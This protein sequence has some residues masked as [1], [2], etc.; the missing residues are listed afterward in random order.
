MQTKR[1]SKRVTAFFL[2]FLLISSFATGLFH[3]AFVHGTV[4]F[5]SDIETGDLSDFTSTFT[6]G[7]TI[8]A[9]SA[10]AHGGTYSALLSGLGSEGECAVAYKSLGA[11]TDT[12]ARA[13][14]R[15]PSLPSSSIATGLEFAWGTEQYYDIVSVGF[16]FS[17]NKWYISERVNAEYSWTTH[18]ESGTS[19]FSADTWYCIELRHYYHASAG[20]LALWVD[21][22][23]KIELTGIVTNGFQT[24]TLWIGNGYSGGY[25]PDQSM[26]IDDIV[27][28]NEYIGPIAETEY[29]PYIQQASDIDSAA[30]VGT[31]SNFTAQ[32]YGPDLI[33]D[34]LT[35]AT[36]LYNVTQI[37]EGFEGDWPPTGWTEDPSNSRWNKDASQKYSGS[38][39]A[40]Y[41][42]ATANVGDLL[43]P[44]L[45][46]TG[47]AAVYISF[48][49]FDDDC[50][51]NE[52]TYDYYDNTGNWDN[53]GDLA[54]STE[55]TF[56]NRINVK[57]TDSQYLHSAFKLRIDGATIG[58]G[59]NFYVDDFL[60][61]A[62]YN[63]YT[64]SLE[65]QFTEIPTGYNTRQLCIY[66]GSFNGAENLMVQGWNTG[67]SSW[68]TISSA[69]TANQWNNLTI[70]SWINELNTTFYIRFIDALQSADAAQ[71]TWQID[72]VYLWMYNSTEQAYSFSLY[73]T[74]A[75]ESTLASQKGVHS[76][77]AVTVGVE[78]ASPFRRLLSRYLNEVVLVSEGTNI[79]KA[80]YR[81][82]DE[83]VAL[84]DG[85]FYSRGALRI[86]LENL[87]ASHLDPAILKALF[88]N[89]D[90][91]L[92]VSSACYYQR[93]LLQTLLQELS[94]TSDTATQKALIRNY[95][96]T[97]SPQ[98]T[99]YYQRELMR[100][101]LEAA[102]TTE[103]LNTQKGLLH[104]FAETLAGSASF[105]FG[106]GKFFILSETFTAAVDNFFNKGFMVWLSEN[107]DVISET[108]CNKGLAMWLAEVFQ[109]NSDL[110]AQ[111]GLSWVLAEILGAGDIAG[112]YRGVFVFLIDGL[113]LD[114]EG[115]VQKSL[116][117]L[118]SEAT[119][120]LDVLTPAKALSFLFSGTVG[121][122][123]LVSWLIDD[124]H[125]A[126]TFVFVEYIVPTGIL[127]ILIELHNWFF[128]GIGTVNVD[129]TVNPHF[130]LGLVSE[131]DAL[132]AIVVACIITA[133]VCLCLMMVWRRKSGD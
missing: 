79:Y 61:I 75:P 113:I 82:Y 62:E 78:G 90:E 122:A 93:A 19:T 5:S 72:A 15:I 94:I 83:T 98:Q 47:A 107:T 74:I 7:A 77:Y 55:D 1:P 69:L 14:V 119:A 32:Q 66:T 111:R 109:L 100:L 54:S 120:L 46:L 41:E 20:V 37:S 91:A 27:V 133:C 127:D 86:L 88:R 34:T 128:E 95:L 58:T 31:H 102:N 6:S 36:A 38:Y 2:L 70:N 116:S 16:D 10:Q 44:A 87:D 112:W 12:Y 53:I 49:Y 65:E 110:A 130:P 4:S 81:N 114:S 68:T 125:L 56:N 26:Y 84:T 35:E 126:L 13:Y 43:S 117:R 85:I 123:D 106:S 67:N 51:A 18:S 105:L 57:V 132:A 21:G 9:S 71:N 3:L 48:Y 29:Y 101:F 92:T 60:I 28:A 22:T 39:S 40:A 80:L 89:Y 131:G 96:E 33:N 30:D 129:G 99:D 24:N 121:I 52:L 64:L 25:T 124:T 11:Q 45:N 42:V 17:S 118:F 63:N 103:N 76:V 73:A 23:S 104:L 108:I 8:A 50:D 59:E 115:L 97:L